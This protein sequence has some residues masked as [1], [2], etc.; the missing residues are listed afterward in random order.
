MLEATIVLQVLLGKLDQAFIIAGL[1]VFNSVLSFLQENQANRS[2][3]LLRSRL[4]VRARVRRDG[5][6]QLIPAEELVPGDAIHLRVADL[7]PADMR[8]FD[9]YSSFCP[10]VAGGFGTGGLAG[11]IYGGDGDRS[12]KIKGQ[13]RIKSQ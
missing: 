8:V 13:L 6:W 12:P 11:N 3:A 10:D 2:L 9:G 4:S 5:Q 1:L 7:A